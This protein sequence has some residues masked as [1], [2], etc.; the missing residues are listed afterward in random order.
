MILPTRI[1]AKVIFIQ[2]TL[3]KFDVAV[4]L[5]NSFE[6][7]EPFSM[8]TAGRPGLVE[9]YLE[10]LSLKVYHLMLLKSYLLIR[11][12]TVATATRWPQSNICEAFL[13][14]IMGIESAFPLD[15]NGFTNC[16]NFVLKLNGSEHYLL[17]TLDM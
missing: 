17:I 2:F 11:G 9:F 14:T 12:V 8:F 1:I 13:I 10:Q 5:F 15:L 16:K 4:H 3:H 7:K 6:S